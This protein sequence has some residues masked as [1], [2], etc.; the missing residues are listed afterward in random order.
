[1]CQILP[2]LNNETTFCRHLVEADAT[3][4]GGS[5]SQEFHYLSHI[6]E[7]KL[8]T[9]RSCN[10]SIDH[11]RN[12]DTADAVTECPSCKSANVEHKKGIEVFDKYTKFTHFAA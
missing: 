12:V 4:M 6:G 7:S 1:M 2:F 9:C 3:S 8:Q 11:T 10:H 5:V